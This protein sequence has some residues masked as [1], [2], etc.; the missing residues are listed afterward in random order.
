MTAINRVSC[1]KHTEFLPWRQRRVNLQMLFFRKFQK[2][3]YTCTW[4]A[5]CESVLLSISPRKTTWS[6]RITQWKGCDKR[7]SSQRD[8][9]TN[10]VLLIA[11]VNEWVCVSECSRTETPCAP[12]SGLQEQFLVARWIPCVWFL[13]QCFALIWNDALVHVSRWQELCVPWQ[14]R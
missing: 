11:W 13:R 12:I 7:S 2:R 9:L 3:I 5:Q 6:F 8:E 4:M 10:R 1:K 14:L